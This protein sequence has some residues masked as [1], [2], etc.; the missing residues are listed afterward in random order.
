MSLVMSLRT[1]FKD[2]PYR[3]HLAAVGSYLILN[4]ILPHG[5]LRDYSPENLAIVVIPSLTLLCRP[6]S[7]PFWFFV[8]L[9]V[10]HL[11]GGIEGII[12]AASWGCAAGGAHL[13]H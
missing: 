11:I 13:T 2:Y 3:K 10:G 7:R 8:G 9:F 12:T 1:H 6:N 5:L 4:L